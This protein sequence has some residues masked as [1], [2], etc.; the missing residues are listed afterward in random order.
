MPCGSLTTISVALHVFVT[1][2][3]AAKTIPIQT[4]IATPSSELPRT[5]G[6]AQQHPVLLEEKEVAGLQEKF[7]KVRRCAIV[8]PPVAGQTNPTAWLSIVCVLP[9][10]ST[11][12]RRVVR[13]RRRDERHPD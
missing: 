9:E 12:R 8:W 11:A 6:C 5:H 7:R 4:F 10:D 2:N 1:T 13:G 3:T